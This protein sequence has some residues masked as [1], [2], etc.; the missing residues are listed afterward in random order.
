MVGG[1]AL[2][3]AAQQGSNQALSH[4]YS[5]ANKFPALAD[6]ITRNTSQA[7]LR[8]ATYAGLTVW[9]NQGLQTFV[10]PALET[11]VNA[12]YADSKE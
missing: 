7:V 3:Q 10:V 12:A 11:T 1:E 2:R 8:N 6:D 9:G 4:S 5:L